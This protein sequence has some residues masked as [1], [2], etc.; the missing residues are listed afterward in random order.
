MNRGSGSNGGSSSSSADD[1][2]GPV[3]KPTLLDFVVG[4]TRAS[5]MAL[6]PL[7]PLEASKGAGKGDLN[8]KSIAPEFK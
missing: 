3:P 7:S 4:Q 2:D 5:I 8:E 1:G 6:P